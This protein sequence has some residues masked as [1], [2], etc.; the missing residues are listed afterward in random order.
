VIGRPEGLRLLAGVSALLIGLL[1]GCQ[2]VPPDL[3]V[4]RAEA[5]EEADLGSFE[6][7][8]LDLRLDPQAAGLQTLRAELTAAGEG[9]GLS[10][11]TRARVISLAAEAALLAGDRAAA[12]SRAEAAAALDASDEGPWLVRA[13]LESDPGRRL[14]LLEQG[15]ARSEGSSRL[16]CER[17]MEL[18][19][20]GR[21]AEAAQDLDEGLRGLDP[22][23]RRLYGADRDRAFALARAAAEGGSAAAAE[24]PEALS[25]ELTVRFMVEKACSKTRLLSSL[26]PAANPAAEQ[27]LPALEAAGLILTPG[28][29][30]APALRKDVAYFIWGI[31]ARVEHDPLLLRKYRAKYTSSPVPDVPVGAP[32][33]DAALGVV[34]RE[35]MD[36]PDG[37]SFQPDAHVTGLEYLGILANLKRQY[38]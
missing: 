21:Y 12:R 32:W 28:P 26:S 34:E 22:G 14:A 18:L 17:G 10:R 4:T 16:R 35:L 27:V 33:F 9:G 24:R 23:Y 37:V 19:K 7:R 25:A 38:P 13:W 30:Q 20:S 1:A 11:R 8:L 6:A 36:L 31:V 2:S 3:T 15:L 29:A 5:A